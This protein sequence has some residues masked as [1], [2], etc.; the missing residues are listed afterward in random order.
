MQ[1]LTEI[2][3]A[4]GSALLGTGLGAYL[5][6]RLGKRKQ[7]ESEFSTLINEY[8]KL[9]EE[10]KFEVVELRK[11]VQ[12]LRLEL[13]AKQMEVTDLRNQLLIFES[14]HADVP[15]PMWL[16]DTDGK[17]LFVNAEYERVILNPLGKRAEDYLGKT[18]TEVWGP[19]IAEKFQKHDR[20]IMRTKKPEIFK[21]TWT[22]QNGDTFTGEI[23]KYPRFLGR[24]II[25]IGG[26]IINMKKDKDKLI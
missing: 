10:Y 12:L 1:Y 5:N 16:K 2:I 18:D 19:E 20:A 13:H 23:I 11:D 22:N 24:T 26:I 4:I 6:F 3:I 14:S 8:K 25:G 21:E 9:V 15:V 17:M 7:S